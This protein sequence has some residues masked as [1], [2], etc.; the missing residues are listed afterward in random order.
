[1]MGLTLEEVGVLF[2][3]I[4]SHLS[5]YQNL[6]YNE[7]LV[8]VMKDL[9][10][11][12]LTKTKKQKHDIKNYIILE[13]LQKN[14]DKI[15]IKNILLS[16]QSK[17]RLPIPTHHIERTR[18]TYKHTRTIR[19]I[20]TNYNETVKTP[21]WTVQCYCAQYNRKFLSQ[22]HGHIVTGDLEILDDL[23]TRDLLRKGLNFR[24]PHKTKKENL[25]T[26]YTTCIDE[27]VIALSG[28]T[29][30]NKNLFNPWRN[31]MLQSI[32]QKI[33][34]MNFKYIPN[35][36]FDY[37]KK[38]QEHFVI[39]PVDKAS[40][41]IGIICKQYYLKVLKEE[42][43]STHFEPSYLDFQTIISN[44][45]QLLR[46]SYNMDTTSAPNNLPFVYWM[47]KFHRSPI[48][49]RFITSGRD[50]VINKE[51]YNWT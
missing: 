17:E 33:D 9:C 40:K 32:S 11:H 6:Q 28:S 15:N 31:Q 39:T 47:P 38:F 24:L 37:L 12:R 46:Q 48:G 49:T 30:T 25:K 20:V 34:E 13:F 10:L 14:M 50:T 19:N 4:N 51:D 16:Q 3:F 23:P 36:N 5:D 26:I 21:N 42:L 41:N 29:N 27:L 7:H 1:M 18:F 45:S 22:H 8:F 43:N 35:F 44:Y 2:L